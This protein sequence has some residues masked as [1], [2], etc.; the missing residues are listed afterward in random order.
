MYVCMYASQTDRLTVTHMSA[1][2]VLVHRWFTQIFTVCRCSRRGRR[3]TDHQICG[4]EE[5]LMSTTL[6]FLLV[7]CIYA[8]DIVVYFIHVWKYQ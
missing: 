1:I 3:G 5:T 2:C 6:K 8:S 7:M 4:A